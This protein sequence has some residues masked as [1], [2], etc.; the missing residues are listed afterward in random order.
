MI[1][2][3]TLILLALVLAHGTWYSLIN[4]TFLNTSDPLLTSK[5]HHLATTYSLASKRSFLN[6]IF[7]KWSW[8][9]S[10][11]AFLPL[12]FTSPLSRTRRFL[13]WFIAT[14]AWFTLTSW[15][16]GPALLTRLTLATGGECGLHIGDSFVPISTTYCSA[17]LPVTRSTHPD[18]FPIVFIFDPAIVDPNRPFLPRLRRGHDVSGHVLLLTLA[19]LFL[20]DQLRQAR[21]SARLYAL[22]ASGSLLS[23]WVFSLWITSVFFHLPS[24]KISGFALGI[25]CFLLS[26]IPLWKPVHAAPAL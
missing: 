19:A 5:Q 2:L 8:A 18:L 1:R 14:I 4:S 21:S 20:A 22:I 23:L 3:L 13:Q 26:Q 24:E 16:F 11:A 10:T 15:F 12:F 17:G 7:L 9:W 25:A 6:V